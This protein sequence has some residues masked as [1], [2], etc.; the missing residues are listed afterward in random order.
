[1]LKAGLKAVVMEVPEPG[2][3]RTMEDC[4]VVDAGFEHLIEKAP[5]TGDQST[6]ET[7]AG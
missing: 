7:D 3:G 2:K 5:E 6:A 1:M 4:A